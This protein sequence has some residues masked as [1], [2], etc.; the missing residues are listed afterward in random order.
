MRL[1]WS[2]RLS[3]RH[4][5]AACP[6]PSWPRS[7][8]PSQALKRRGC[9]FLVAPYE[10]DAQM[11]YLALNGLVD[12]VLTEDSDLLCYGCPKAS[13]SK[14]NAGPQRFAPI[15]ALRGP[16]GTTAWRCWP[17]RHACH[18]RLLFSSLQ[19][20][21]K[22]DKTGE[23]EE[24]QLCELPQARELAFQGFGHDLFQE[25]GRRRV[26]W[27]GTEARFSTLMPGWLHGCT[28]MVPLST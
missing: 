2:R 28:T 21:F 12:A 16:L 5:L 19:V 6:P 23:G 7:R 25:V 1:L 24:V 8:A 18:H 3:Q 13:M 4:P 17:S 10:A 14:I 20:F 9:A 22:M 27:D 11:A 26:E 15:C